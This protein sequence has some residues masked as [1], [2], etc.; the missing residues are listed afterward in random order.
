MFAIS[1]AVKRKADTSVNDEEVDVA[2]KKSAL[3]DLGDDYA[4][5][6]DEYY[7]D[8]GPQIDRS[9]SCPYLDTINR[10][11]LDFLQLCLVFE[12]YDE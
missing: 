11:Y 3:G 9:R 6:D 12:I 1:Q 10:W 4:S 2:V 7:Y 8:D 5:G